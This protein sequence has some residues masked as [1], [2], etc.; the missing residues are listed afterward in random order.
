M[1]MQ[2]LLSTAASTYLQAYLWLQLPTSN[3][4]DKS[5]VLAIAAG[6]E[7]AASKQVR[8]ERAE[9]VLFIMLMLIPISQPEGDRKFG[10]HMRRKRQQQQKRSNSES[11]P[12][13]NAKAHANAMTESNAKKHNQKQHHP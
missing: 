8:E 4:P 9:L 6:V 1:W 12:K 2:P 7:V 5:D 13:P 3:L 10:G 11:K